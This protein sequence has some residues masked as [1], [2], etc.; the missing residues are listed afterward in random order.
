M[1]W[2]TSLTVARNR[3]AITAAWIT[4]PAFSARNEAPRI[5]F[6]EASATNLM[7]PRVSR[8]TMARGTDDSGRTNT[9]TSR[10]SVYA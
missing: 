1:L 7:S 2:A 10:P 9:S 3:R 4:S 8:F 5:S 6:V